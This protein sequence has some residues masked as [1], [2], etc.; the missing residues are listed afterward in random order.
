MGF[1]MRVYERFVEWAVDRDGPGEYKG[2]SRA[3]RARE[4]AATVG[5]LR[6]LNVS[7]ELPPEGVIEIDGDGIGSIVNDHQPPEH[8]ELRVDG[9]VVKRIPLLITSDGCSWVEV[10]E[11]DGWAI[12][13]PV[14]D[15]WG[16]HPVVEVETVPAPV[17]GFD[18]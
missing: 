8:I 2:L 10:V 6:D 1:L 14:E 16:D 17:E 7:L 4:D 15:A 9:A 13:P 18:W 5:W 11:P 12:Q 3:A